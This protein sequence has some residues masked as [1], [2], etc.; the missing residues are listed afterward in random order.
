[1]LVVL[2]AT[3]A[4]ATKPCP[5]P[6]CVGTA[7]GEVAV[8]IADGRIEDIVH[9]RQPPPLFKDFAKFTFRPEKWARGAPGPETMAFRIRWCQNQRELP[10]DTSG[11]FRF[12]G[13]NGPEQPELFFLDFHRVGS[14]VERQDVA[15]N[16]GQRVSLRGKLVRDPSTKGG[17]ENPGTV[18]EIGDGTRFWI[19][20]GAPPEGLAPHVGREVALDCVVW[21]D[22]PPEKIEAI[23]GP[24]LTAC[25][26]SVGGI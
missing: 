22:S 13:S 8:W 4:F 19:S 9:D 11:T 6:A 2:V 15:P 20:Y 10:A 18:L 3:A 25:T 7:C 23:A 12:Y 17:H 21:Q 14:V 5:P 16:D 1:M 26:P 24:H